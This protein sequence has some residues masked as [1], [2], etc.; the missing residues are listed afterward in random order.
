VGG[1]INPGGA[2]GVF[3]QSHQKLLKMTPRNLYG[4]KALGGLGAHPVRGT[5]GTAEDGYLWRQMVIAEACKRGTFKFPGMERVERYL[6]YQRAL[7]NRKF[8]DAVRCQS[9]GLPSKAASSDRQWFEYLNI[10]ESVEGCENGLRS[11]VAWMA[12]YE[13][14]CRVNCKREWLVVNRFVKNLCDAKQKVVAMAVD[15]YL[16][17]VAEDYHWY[18]PCE[19]LP[20]SEE[21][22]SIFG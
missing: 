9:S 7:L 17:F 21:I 13:K 12:K 18:S 14:T 4:P 22:E 16:N 1:A 15:D 10:D 8:P 20:W 5:R 6:E 11:A 2:A 19:V 3:I